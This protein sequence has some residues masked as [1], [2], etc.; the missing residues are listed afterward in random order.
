MS[1]HNPLYPFDDDE[2]NL[3]KAVH[4]AELIDD[5]EKMLKRNSIDTH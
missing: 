3:S 4:E 5:T 1:L 2:D